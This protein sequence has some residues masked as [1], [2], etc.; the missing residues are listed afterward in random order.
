[1]RNCS[2]KG[3]MMAGSA[4]VAL[5]VFAAPSI[6]VAQTATYSFN[7]PAQDLDA[8][9]RAYGR[10]ARQQVV[11]DSQDTRGK[12]STAL[13]GTFAADAGLQQLLAGTG[14]TV[15]RG[16]SGV[17][18]VSDPQRAEAAG[19]GSPLQG[20]DRVAVSTLEEVVVTGT[21]IR[22]AAPVGSPVQVYDQE[23]FELAGADTPQE[24]MAT[25]TQNF[26]GAQ[27]ADR[28]LDFTYGSGLDL[29]G[30]GPGTTLVLLNGR[31]MPLSGASSYVDISMIP[32][33]AIER[34]EVL[35]DGASAI[36]G[37][38]A[39]GGVVNIITRSNYTGGDTSLSVSIP[40]RGGGEEYRASQS[41]GTSWGSGNAFI[42]AEAYSIEP[43]LNDGRDV[44]TQPG[45]EGLLLASG[46]ERLSLVGSLQQ[47]LSATVRLTGD[48]TYSERQARGVGLFQNA[49][50]RS[51]SNNVTSAVALGLNFELPR[52]WTASI[53]AALSRADSEG[54]TSYDPPADYAFFRDFSFEGRGVDASASGVLANLPTGAL[55]AAFGAGYREDTYSSNGADRY[56]PDTYPDPTPEDSV[57]TSHAFAEF[58]VPLLGA[59]SW[60]AEPRLQLSVAG[61]YDDYEG[62]GSSVDPRV[63]VELLASPD[64]T[65]RAA[66]STSF[67]APTLE[68]LKTTSN[69]VNVFPATILGVPY[70]LLSVNGVDPDL[71]PE[72]STNWS[73]GFVW[74]PASLRGLSVDLN[75]YDI[76]YQDRIA[77]P[78]ASTLDLIVNPAF[79]EIGIIRGEIPDAEFDALV[80]HYLSGDAGPVRQFCGPTGNAPCGSSPSDYNFISLRG[81]LTNLAQ[82]HQSGIDLRLRQSIDAIAGGQLEFGLDLTYILDLTRRVTANSPEGSFLNRLSEPVSRRMRG[83]VVWRGEAWTLAGYANYVGEHSNTD[84]APSEPI[85][86]STTF[87]ATVRWDL[88]RDS[89]NGALSGLQLIFNV[90]NVF[91]DLPPAYRTANPSGLA[92]DS[93]SNDPWGR[94]ISL[95]LTKS[96]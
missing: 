22:G 32:I 1:M 75:W 52:D 68:Q 48:I 4:A 76:S 21:H 85:P 70:R 67:R 45:F 90:N 65:V 15:R 28:D 12:R 84:V 83:S 31:R 7:I 46:Q 43:V 16:S 57:A 59:P 72:T 6:V 53:I 18:I 96:W 87:D 58:N 88:G 55:R 24:F 11:F 77:F 73:A 33:S 71:G 34:I 27:S 10:A 93:A 13:V 61:R 39:V 20:D 94:V 26:G 17:L 50:V 63:G 35:T 5:A 78:S 37:S 82:T 60:A 29:R 38:D 91:D 86:S 54:T 30:L 44:K 51:D 62:F 79:D 14:L 64:L 92:Y 89:P 36:Y 74:E 42:S 3:S 69:G 8:A 49:P 19:P 47:D 56:G 23:D 9:L 66:Y 95:T 40:T 25:V 81:V 80:A 2:F 41:F